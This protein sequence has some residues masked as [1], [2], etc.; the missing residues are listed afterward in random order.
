MA[1]SFAL[2]AT[3]AFAQTKHA[4]I[5]KMD[6]NNA[7]VAT[8]QLSDMP[9]ASFNAS[10]F[11]KAE[12]DTI[13]TWDF[14][15]SKNDYTL[16]VVTA[17]SDSVTFGLPN[18]TTLTQARHDNNNSYSHWRRL[19]NPSD[20][21]L[22]NGTE[23]PW[24]STNNN[25]WRQNNGFTRLEYYCAP[26]RTD[27][28]TDN[29]FMFQSLR[30]FT[31]SERGAINSYI[32]L[33]AQDLSGVAIAEVRFFQLYEK[34]YDQCFIDYSSNG[35]TWNTMEINVDGIDMNVNDQLWNWARYTL[36]A[37]A[38]SAT[39]NLRIRYY[40][41]PEYRQVLSFGYWWAIDDISLVEGKS[42]N[43]RIIDANFAE[44]AYQ[45]MPQGMEIPI[46]WYTRVINNGVVNQTNVKGSVYSYDRVADEATLIAESATSTLT[47]DP[48][49][50]HVIKI[51]PAGWF[52]DDEVD[53]W[54]WY[55]DM[56][57]LNDNHVL[58]TTTTG[59]KQVV[60]TLSSDIFGEIGLD[61]ISYRVNCE[62][63]G[64]R[65]W[66]AD[67]GILTKRSFFGYG[68]DGNYIADTGA[69]SSSGYRTTL[70]YM[71]GANVP[72][73]WVLR[74]V[75][76]VVTTE[77][78]KAEAHA[79][80]SPVAY[81][82][83]VEGTSVSF[84]TLNTGAGTYEVQAADFAENE[85][86]LNNLDYLEPGDYRTIRIMFPNQ[87]ELEPYS[88]YRLGY[89]LLEDANFAVARTNNRYYVTSATGGDSVVRFS[90]DPYLK[91]WSRFFSNKPGLG[92]LSP[93]QS[94]TYDRS[95]TWGNYAE[96]V[97]MIRA[98]V[99]P[100][101]EF[102]KYDFT[103][104]CDSTEDAGIEVGYIMT[105]TSEGSVCG[106]TQQIVEGATE[107]FFI[108]YQDGYD[109]R[110][111]VDGTVITEGEYDGF[112]YV[113]YNS[114]YEGFHYGYVEFSNVHAAHSINVNYRGIPESI[115]GVEGVSMKLQPNPAT[116][117][118]RLS[119]NGVTGMV[120]CALIDMSGRVVMSQNINAENAQV[121]DLS[122]VAKGAYFV[123]IT[124]NEFSK[125]EKL[126]VR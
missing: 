39:T 90:E 26:E 113:P 49:T 11:T 65:I 84:V 37:A 68:R 58:P 66:G 6:R 120:N 124:N 41:D 87:P 109:P 40:A 9:G 32:A 112:V 36:P 23:Y 1:L 114:D 15:A 34:Y 73:G 101:Q 38:C 108:M 33:A 93:Y 62:A 78:G 44:G 82:D 5:Q 56:A 115:D 97:P 80:I 107:T 94:L 3:F 2:C 106:T 20:P 117:Q 100:A 122:N 119:L 55:G 4:T 88:S 70:R 76:M 8:M 42:E 75:E 98:I 86:A 47:P 24:W 102:E 48:T 85:A 63:D 72:E 77:P 111:T 95:W 54:G 118:V 35:T 116:S 22:D 19:N 60:T 126:I 43:W 103:I 67:N 61:T 30:E 7:A 69:F 46:A 28:T 92:M 52:A 25:A 125:I 50:S 104:T 105:N 31:A 96:A 83:E 110:V 89:T 14:A 45:W 91:D 57:M 27:A 71:T 81:K 10:I 121:I 12:G 18:G 59:V 79:Q 64:S 17:S 16:G 13:Y 99:G 21:I 123:R 74:G 53:N 51:D 29:G